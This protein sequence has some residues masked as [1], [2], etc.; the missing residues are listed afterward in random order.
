MTL[1]QEAT[2]LMQRMPEQN[3]RLVVELLRTMNPVADKA[4]DMLSSNPRAR[5]IG[6]AVNEISLPDDFD[7]QFDA[8]DEEIATM[9][10]GNLE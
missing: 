1:V 7:E 5:R 9:F 3:V 4:A 6:A 8:L 2:N 10:Y